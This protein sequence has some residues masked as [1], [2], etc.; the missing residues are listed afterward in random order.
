MQTFTIV[1]TPV[2]HEQH[3]G[4]ATTSFLMFRHPQTTAQVS[5][6]RPQDLAQAIADW[7]HSTPLP[8]VT[9]WDDKAVAVNAWSVHVRKPARW[10]QG[11]KAQGERTHTFVVA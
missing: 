1:G 5:V 6:E 9:D 3:D 10:P 8:E 7:A 11:F 4:Y 2:T